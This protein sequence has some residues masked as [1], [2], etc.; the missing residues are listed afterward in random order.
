MGLPMDFPFPPPKARPPSARRAPDEA[1]WGR[2]SAAPAEFAKDAAELPGA[3]PTS[4]AAPEIGNLQDLLTTQGA[5]NKATIKWVETG[6]EIALYFYLEA[7]ESNEPTGSSWI[8]PVGLPNSD[9]W[10]AHFAQPASHHPPLR[11]CCWTSVFVLCLAI[12]RKIWMYSH[13]Y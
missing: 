13:I 12:R 5:P 8:P 2:W 11:W 7:F 9:H 1:P 6:K 4:A 10:D 3:G